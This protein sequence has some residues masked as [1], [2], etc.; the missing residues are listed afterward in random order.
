MRY[1]AYLSKKLP[2]VRIP[3]RSLCLIS[4]LI[5]LLSSILH[6]RAES[7]GDAGSCATEWYTT[8]TAAAA[9]AIGTEQELAG[10]AAL[11][12]GGTTA[13]FYR[14]TLTLTAD[15][16]LSG[17]DW[18]PIGTLDRPFCGTFDGAGKAIGGLVINA[19]ASDCQALFGATG[20][21]AVLGNLTLTNVSVYGHSYVA[22]LAGS[23]YGGQ[24]VNCTVSGYVSG[25]YRYIG[26]IVGSLSY[27]S[28]FNCANSASIHGGSRAGG[29][30][31][32]VYRGS[33]ENCANMGASVYGATAGG[34]IGRL[35]SDYT[36]ENCMSIASVSG[37]SPLGGV[38]GYNYSGDTRSCYWRRDGTA[39]L[40]L[41]V[42]TGST[43]ASCYA[44]DTAPGF[45]TGTAYGTTN[46]LAAL[47][48]W[49]GAN[50]RP[51]VPYRY[52]TTLDSET[53]YP[54]L[55]PYATYGGM[56]CDKTVTE[57]VRGAFTNVNETAFDVWAKNH[58]V[59]ADAVTHDSLSAFLGNVSPGSPLFLRAIEVPASGA[60]FTFEAN[61]DF[62]AINGTLEVL[63][64]DDLS[65]LLPVDP[66]QD[67]DM[68]VEPGPTSRLHINPL[69]GV[70]SRF[71]RVRIRK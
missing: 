24:I 54:V 50:Q 55:T 37:S 40:D 61:F 69:Q 62:S 44:F 59:T 47:S 63:A 2:A 53:E 13:G 67:D 8:N 29:I 32:D 39:G 22:G 34:V 12:N 19:P 35:D 57:E 26:G 28:L 70:A 25:T 3:T 10:L 16:N 31:G 27:G 36:V 15:L 7:W 43:Y 49:V 52:W 66:A 14:K 18:V 60:M 11:V 5:F 41:S 9:F 1:A 48:A 20:S 21:G 65:N 45:L 51:S 42:G 17:K 23:A 30:A 4:P 68:T 64:G 58:A 38:I 71:Y 6:L 56:M 33:V 46:L